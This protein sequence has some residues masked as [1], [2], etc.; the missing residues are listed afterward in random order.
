MLIIIL[1]YIISVVL[2]INIL[3]KDAK[4]EGVPLTPKHILRYYG[5]DVIFV[6]IP[7]FNTIIVLLWYAVQWYYEFM[8]RY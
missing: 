2:F 7:V 6:I 5:F 8:D 4:L 1:F 3:I